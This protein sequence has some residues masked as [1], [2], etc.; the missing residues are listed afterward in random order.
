MPRDGMPT[1]SIGMIKALG[2][3]LRRLVQVSNCDLMRVRFVQARIGRCQVGVYGGGC[4]GHRS[5]EGAVAAEKLRQVGLG[6][7]Q[8]IEMVY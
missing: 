7:R 4:Q 6:R 2:A 8:G 5:R 3:V 1:S